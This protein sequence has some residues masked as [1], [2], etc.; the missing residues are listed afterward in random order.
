MAFF[1]FP[2]PWD[3]RYA[4]PG[5]VRAEPA[6]RGTLVTQGLRRGTID[7]V[8]TPRGRWAVPGYVMTESGQGAITTAG[9]PRRFVDVKAPDYLARSQVITRRRAVASSRPGLGSLSGT[10]FSRPTLA[11]PR[12]ARQRPFLALGDDAWKS[13][14]VT[15]LGVTFT[16]VEINTGIGGAQLL[17]VKGKDGPAST[18]TISKARVP[19]E[20]AAVINSKLSVKAKELLKANPGYAKTPLLLLSAAKHSL[21]LIGDS[22]FFKKYNN[23]F[24]GDIAKQLRHLVV[25][26]LSTVGGT[27]VWG[28]NWIFQVEEIGSSYKLSIVTTSDA[29]ALEKIALVIT[30]PLAVIIKTGVDVVKTGVEGA[31]SA[32]Q[33][34]MDTACA[35]AQDD[36][37]VLTGAAVSTAYGAPPQVGAQAVQIVGAICKGPTAP[38]PPPPM[39]VPSVP[40]LPIA[41]AAAGV[42]L[43][44]MGLRE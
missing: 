26:K 42:L 41:I 18:V 19:A 27:D 30:K 20:L 13:R 36:L 29:N 38:A 35:A 9:L 17:P 28:K 39:V 3:P 16:V 37:G 7:T 21:G 44:A 25:A 22:D 4:L 34:I 24:T 5:S 10:V 32:L 33:K 11:S 43:I 6:G 40:I 1:Q 2:H 23:G 12:R 14:N 8:R 15:V 31:L